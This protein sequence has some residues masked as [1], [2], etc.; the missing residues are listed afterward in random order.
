MQ[1]FDQGVTDAGLKTG[2]TG[3]VGG[4]PCRG[5]LVPIVATSWPSFN[6]GNTPRGGISGEFFAE[7]RLD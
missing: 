5:V 4:R 1:E 3:I 6:R 7:N 2:I